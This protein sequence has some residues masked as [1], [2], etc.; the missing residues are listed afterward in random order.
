[1]EAKK[2]T[3]KRRI[4][5]VQI[6]TR[7]EKL[8][9]LKAALLKIRVTGMTVTPVFGCGLSRGMKETYRGQSVQITLLPKIKVEI[10]AYEVS[11]EA[12]INAAVS[13]CRTGHIGDGKI[14]VTEVA[15][16]VRIRTGERGGA[17]IAD[18]REEKHIID[19]RVSGDY[20]GN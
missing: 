19:R 3:D 17:A 20:S 13:A 15:D 5:C 12:I 4:Y 1:M 8:E 14:F 6:I 18:R 11:P 9:E 7:P 16:A 10:V 2:E